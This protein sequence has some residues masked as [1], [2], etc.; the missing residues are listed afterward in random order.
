ME[1]RIAVLETQMGRIVSD[2]ESEKET[3]ARVNSDIM[4]ALKEHSEA[5]SRTDKILYMGLGGLATL[6]FVLTLLHK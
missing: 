2:I 6:Q 3:R 5:Q 1:I 4:I